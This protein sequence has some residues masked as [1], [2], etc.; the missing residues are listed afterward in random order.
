MQKIGQEAGNNMCD[1]LE[2][3][4]NKILSIMR[5]FVHTPSPKTGEKLV[6]YNN[7]ENSNFSWDNW[8]PL[9]GKGNR[10]LYPDYQPY[11][12]SGGT[13]SG[14][15][16]VVWVKENVVP[17]NDGLWLI[18]TTG[19]TSGSTIYPWQQTGYYNLNWW[20]EGTKHSFCGQI[21]TM[22]GVSGFSF[23]YG[24]VN[25]VA[26]MPP[27]G[28]T[29]FP[30]FWLYNADVNGNQ[31]PEID[32]EIFGAAGGYPWPQLM[33]GGPTNYMMF[34]IHP[35]ITG[36]SS[37]S[38]GHTFS[39][40]LDL[41]FHKYSLKWTPTQLTWLVDDVAYATTTENIPNEKMLLI[42]GIQSGT[43][44]YTVNQSSYTYIFND[45]ECNKKL[46]IKSIAI[47]QN[48]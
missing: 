28:Y 36:V 7:F 9:A 22:C 24:T 13:S 43:Q 5:H 40:D 6:F 4:K 39:T 35:P 20:E 30:A 27:S 33:R 2:R 23:R 8:Y 44:D 42:C 14:G 1:L 3:F 21:S 10:G 11:L 16:R 19:N 26:K 45:S 37:F 47:Y 34:S 41:D 18:A 12:P 48:I 38:V 46:I 17:S 31:K 25:I 15:H 32:F 29:Y